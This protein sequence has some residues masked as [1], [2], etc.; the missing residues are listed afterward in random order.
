MTHVIPVAHFTTDDLPPQG[1]YEAWRGLVASVFEPRPAE[2]SRGDVRARVDA[3][4]LGSALLAHAA[5]EAQYFHRTKRLI[6]A[7]NLDH[8]LI[9]V[10]QR[11]ECRG[12]YGGVQNVVSAGDVRIIDLAR[13]FSSF[14]TEFDNISLT[15]PRAA[16]A[17]LLARPDGLHGAVLPKA[18][19]SAQILASHIRQLSAN[20]AAFCPQDASTLGAASISLVASCL[21]ASARDRARPVHA[22]ATG[23]AVRDYIER[24]LLSP[25]LSP[26]LLARQFRLSRAQLYRLFP[27]GGVAAYIKTRRLQACFLALGA[28]GSRT[29]TI[30]QI[31]FRFGFTSEAHFSRAFRAAFDITPSEARALRMSGRVAVPDR[32]T[33]LSDWLHGLQALPPA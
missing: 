12:A 32:G 15:I 23:R 24:S 29:E 13:P 26:A 1:R 4:H 28:A 2:P 6:A 33:F 25:T 16:L 18:C 30:G 3:I 9:Q 7:E 10:Y 19:A 11:G 17:P 27:E 31:A 5:A 21:G 8:Y 22:V 20:A 14:N